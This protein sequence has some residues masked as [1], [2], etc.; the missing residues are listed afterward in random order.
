M[1]QDCFLREENINSLFSSDIVNI[2]LKTNVGTKKANLL[3]LSA[4]IVDGKVEKLGRWEGGEA[5]KVEGW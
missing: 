1:V 4:L 5:G 2:L 3:F